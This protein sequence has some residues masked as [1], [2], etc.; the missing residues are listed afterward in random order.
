MAEKNH[1]E[2]LRLTRSASQDEIDSQYHEL[3]YQHHPT[4]IQGMR[5]IS[6]KDHRPGWP[7]TAPFLTP[8]NGSYTIFASSILPSTTLRPRDEA[9]QG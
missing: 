2:I 5:K 9:A 3:L 8:K 4:A 7:P 6:G 1:Y